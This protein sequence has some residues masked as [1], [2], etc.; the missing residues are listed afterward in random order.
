MGS[1]LISDA[2][3]ALR[4]PT[5]L[6]F[7]ARMSCPRP[8]ALHGGEKHGLL[9]R[10]Q[11]LSACTVEQKEILHKHNPHARKGRKNQNAYDVLSAAAQLLQ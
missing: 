4:S 9:S 11:V 6:M 8:L 7:F 5:V 2:V 10:T 3:K 1:V